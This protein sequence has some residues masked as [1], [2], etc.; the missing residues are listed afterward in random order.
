[1]AEHTH[2]L[3]GGLCRL[4]WNLPADAGVDDGHSALFKVAR[5]AENSAEVREELAGLF[6][7]WLATERESISPTQHCTAED[8]Y[9]F[10]H[11]AS[12][13][14]RPQPRKCGCAYDYPEER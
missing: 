12:Y 1:M 8:C 7:S 10:S 9:T 6:G 13:C 2:T 3:I 5:M 4:A 14:G 11:T